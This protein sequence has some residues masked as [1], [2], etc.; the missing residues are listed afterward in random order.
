MPDK[1]VNIF[2]LIGQSN[3]AGRGDVNEVEP[4]AHPNVLML[5]H[6]LWTAAQDPLHLDKWVAGVGLGVSFGVDLAE[7][8]PDALI[9]L[10]PAAIGGTPLERWMPG[11][12]LYRRAVLEAQQAMRGGEIRGILWHQGCGDSKSEDRANS[13]GDRFCA[14]IGALRRELDC[15]DAPVV[16]GEFG[17][18]LTAREGL[19]HFPTVNAQLNSL[20]E[21]VPRCA[22]VSS[23]G[24]NHKGDDVHFD[25][26]GLRELGRR[27]AEAYKRLLAESGQSL[28]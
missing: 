4:L 26:P 18:F 7:S 5:R 12:Y 23:E 1:K 17:R 22:C 8:F 13:Y 19:C 25:S 24:L 20:A 16:V 11:A 15:E 6:G 10:T 2:L 3:M 14:M 27:Y 28:D 9:G 21:R